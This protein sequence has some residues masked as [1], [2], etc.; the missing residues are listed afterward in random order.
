MKENA[1]SLRKQNICYGPLKKVKDYA[2]DQ[3]ILIPISLDLR[4][5]GLYLMVR[6]WQHNAVDYNQI[7]LFKQSN[8]TSNSYF[9]RKGPDVKI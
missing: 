9:S 6:P 2:G 8:S 5:I 7:Y 4:D 3:N 1:E